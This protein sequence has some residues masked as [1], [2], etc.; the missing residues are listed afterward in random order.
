MQQISISQR[1]YIIV[2]LIITIAMFIWGANDAFRTREMLLSEK[3]I[4]LINLVT[5]LDRQIESVRY[6]V[7]AELYSNRSDDEKRHVLN[8]YLQPIVDNLSRE[9]PGYGL[10]IYFK[11]LNI[12]AVSPYSPEL[13]GTRDATQSLVT[14]QQ[15]EMALRAFDP[16]P[17]RPGEQL[18]SITYPISVYGTIV[19]HSW[20][21]YAVSDFEDDLFSMYI[22]RF[23]LALFI[24]LAVLL[25]VDHA[26][27]RIKSSLHAFS[28]DIDSGVY[29]PA[30]IAALPELLPVIRTVESLKQRLAQEYEE[31]QKAKE[32]VFHLDRLNL[33]SQMAAGVAH[34]IRNPMTT[35]TGFLQL[36][37]RKIDESLKDNIQLVLSELMRIDSIITD[38]LSLA[39]NKITEK[40]ELQL[41]D[42]INQM[43]PFLYAEAT[44]QGLVVQY[45]LDDEVSLLNLDEKEI[46]Q[47]VLNLARN[48]FQAM[49]SQGTL[50]IETRQLKNSVMLSI[51]DTGCGIS[52]SIQD[53]IFDPFYTTKPDG[54]GLG[55]SICKSIV[56]RHNGTITIKSKSGQGTTVSISFP[57]MQSA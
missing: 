11:E 20:A 55:L 2:S 56:D 13:I 43:S 44:K 22:E 4:K 32:Q 10:G 21:N 14:Y 42:I 36:I 39:R 18:L 25:V 38:F 3:R 26:F 31:K 7:F 5:T 15:Y 27:S 19:G 28:N 35:I 46:K 45:K 6:L 41:N 49:G 47:L 37:H 12:T 23:V 50:K 8:K 40:R 53:K 1:T 24:W 9:N 29:D 17:S 54:T 51:S 30:H 16:S 52:E 33:V 57:L 34:E 48:S